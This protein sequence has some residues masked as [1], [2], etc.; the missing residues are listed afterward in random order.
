MDKSW[1]RETIKAGV[2]LWAALALALCADS[3][4]ALF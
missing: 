4:G 1:K 2:V 3:L